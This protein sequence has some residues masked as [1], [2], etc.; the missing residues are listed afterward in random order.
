[1]RSQEDTGDLGVLLVRNLIFQIEKK[2]K[3]IMK[4]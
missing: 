4:N 2:L 3:T 1:M